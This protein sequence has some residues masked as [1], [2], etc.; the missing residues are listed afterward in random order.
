MLSRPD[1]IIIK[2]KGSSSYLWETYYKSIPQGETVE[3][4]TLNEDILPETAR[5]FDIHD[6]GGHHLS[7]VN[8]KWAELKNPVCCY[9]DKSVVDWKPHYCDYPINEVEKMVPPSAISLTSTISYMIA[10]AGVIMPKRVY[11]AGVDFCMKASERVVQ[12]R[13]A[14]RWLYFL[15]GSGVELVWPSD[16]SDLFKQN[17]YIYK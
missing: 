4:W 7:T 15:F 2:G 9:V 8:S 11:L 1:N 3:L 16:R 5:H 14:E 13:D 17:K 6:L 10:L 12:A